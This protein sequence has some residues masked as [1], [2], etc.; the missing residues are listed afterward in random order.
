MKKIWINQFNYG[1]S[2][3]LGYGFW[4]AL[5]IGLGYRL[6]YRLGYGFSYGLR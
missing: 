4:L 3:W 1:F 2:H 5:I 6:G